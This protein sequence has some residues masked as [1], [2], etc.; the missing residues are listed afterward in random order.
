MSAKRVLLGITA[1]AAAFKGVSMASLLRKRGFAVDAVL[2]K[3]AT[4]LIS[5]QQI[6]CVT[7]RG[8]YSDLWTDLPDADPI[9]HIS[10]TEDL[11][12]MVIAPASASFLAR[13]SLG[14]ADELLTTAALAC[15]S[16]M[17][18]APAM[19]SRMWNN[20]VTREHVERLGGRGV[21]FAG[22]VEGEL[23]CGTRGA[24]RMMEPEEI[25]QVCL[26][27]IL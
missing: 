14:L 17:V 8:V 18:V 19:N 10:L 23:A 7:G 9:P 27:L 13:L 5:P 6:A 3:N 25:L 16:P 15:N 4:R 22:P 2:S 11:A 1:S 26:E 24:G 20:P 12:L 21:V